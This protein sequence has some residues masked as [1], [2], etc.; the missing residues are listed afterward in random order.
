MRRLGLHDGQTVAARDDEQALARG[1]RAVVAA[2]KLPH[3]EFV[4]EVLKL[5]APAAEGEALLD[6]D[7]LAVLVERTPI[8][9]FLH[10]LHG[11]DARVRGCRRRAAA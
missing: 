9:E 3:I 6:L 2:L 11:D 1:G 10:V 7:D 5:A 8:G 4:A